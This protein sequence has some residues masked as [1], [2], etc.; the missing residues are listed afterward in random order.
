MKKKID[1]FDEDIKITFFGIPA[2]NIKS[3]EL[4]QDYFRKI[5]TFYE[6]YYK[7]LMVVWLAIGLGVFFIFTFFGIVSFSNYPASIFGA[8]LIYIGV[9]ILFLTV[10]AVRFF[11]RNLLKRINK[12]FE[13]IERHE[14]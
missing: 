3:D 8:F 7:S 2:P 4:R 11:H 13:L 9:F 6:S 1:L 12:I 10:S 14:W 5:I